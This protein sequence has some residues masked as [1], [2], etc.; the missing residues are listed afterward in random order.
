MV[1]SKRISI[2]MATYNG[3]QYIKVQL[4]SILKQLNENDEVVISDDGST[5]RTIDII[6]SFN[7][8]RI[9]IYQ[10]NFQDVVLNFENVLGKATGDIIFLSDQDDIWY[11][12]KVMQSLKLL[13][14]YDLLFSNLSV[15]SSDPGEYVNMYSPKSNYQGIHRNFIKN[16]CVGATMAFKSHLLKYALPFPKNIEMHDIWIFFI[17]SFYGKTFY[18]NQPL[19]YYRRHGLNVSNTGGKS[20]NSLIKIIQIRITWI[21]SLIKRITKIYFQGR[22]EH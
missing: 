19:I 5:D 10:G 9:K 17:S 21:I 2:C 20:T 13:E 11:D 14:E 7:D 16:H 12:C 3:E 1:G 4:E 6:N 8:P 18:Y 15:F 22:N